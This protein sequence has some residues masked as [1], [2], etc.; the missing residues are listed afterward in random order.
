MRFP[1]TIHTAMKGVT[2]NTSRSL[3]T[4][5][6]III[7]VAS[8]VLMS[9]V[10]ASMKLVIHTGAKCPVEVK[11]AMIDWFG[12]VLVESYGGSESGTLCRISSAGVVADVEQH[13]ERHRP[14]QRQPLDAVAANAGIPKGE[15]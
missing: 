13:G 6:G 1:D 12:P 4:M 8:V 15:G 11:R 14:Q 2:V 9:S 3:L 10:G 7:G 5:L